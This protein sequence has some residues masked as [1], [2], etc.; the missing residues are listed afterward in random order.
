M[1]AEHSG[2][3]KA[4]SVLIGLGIS[5]LTMLLL[6]IPVSLVV[7]F[8]PLQDLHLD[9]LALLIESLALLAGG[10]IAAASA[11]ERGLL[12]GLVTAGLALLLLFFLNQGSGSMGL[13]LLLGFLAGGIG[14]VLGVR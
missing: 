9:H 3:N 5:L 11:R 6:S 2:N 1:H 14:G 7:H 4:K 13:K 8:S 10:F 12:L